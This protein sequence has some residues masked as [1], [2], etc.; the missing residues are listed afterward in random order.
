MEITLIIAAAVALSGV[1]ILVLLSSSKYLTF[2]FF[3]CYTLPFLPLVAALGG[4]DSVFWPSETFSFKSSS[5][6]VYGLALVWICSS[7]GMLT[8]L[9]M[10]KRA[11][12][13]RLKPY[14]VKIRQSN[15]DMAL[16]N[17][18]VLRRILFTLLGGSV[19][20]RFLF[21]LEIEARF[22][23]MDVF[24]CYLFTV[25]WA[26]VL[27]TPRKKL[28]I[29]LSV[30]TGVYV[31]S[32]ISSGDRDFFTFLFALGLLWMVKRRLRF[33]TLLKIVVASLIL[34]IGGTAIS[35][36]RMDIDF[37]LEQLQFFLAF[38]SWNAI[39]L[40]VLIMIGAE[41]QNGPFLFGKTYIDLLLSAFPSPIYYLLDFPKPITTDNPA[42]WF[43]IQGLG[44]MHFSGVA[45][46][47]FGLIGVYLQ[48][49]LFAFGLLVVER[50]VVKRNSG[51]RSLLFLVVAASVM[52]TTWYGLIYF[53]NAMTFYI[54]IVVLIYFFVL[55]RGI[56]Q[57]L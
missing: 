48:V 12:T 17:S 19:I 21:H 42:N 32:Q 38:N 13:M 45:L 34:V 49:M 16:S 8:A 2:F 35:M 15:C 31:F 3:L 18:R 44:G 29:Q 5:I 28:F 41:W 30:I 57:K 14:I 1:L 43:Y 25:C 22:P 37:S 33:I 24:I 27:M 39:I 9:A 40:P 52:H 10:V 54:S 4:F 47:N 7:L 23:G 51:L 26:I 20:S 36:A 55:L 50:R 46:R 11:H 6:E 56:R 53:I